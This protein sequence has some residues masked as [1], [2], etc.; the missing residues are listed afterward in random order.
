MKITLLELKSKNSSIIYKDFAGGLGPGF[1]VGKSIFSKAIE[2]AKAKGVNLPIV[3]FGYLYSILSKNGHNVE[4][5]INEIPDSDLVLI[6]SSLCDYKLEIEMAAKIKK[7]TKAKVGFI[8]PL[9]SS[10]PELFLEVADFIIKGEPEYIVS[11]LSENWLPEGIVESQDIKNLDDLP[12]PD[13]N[14]FPVNKTSYSPSLSVRPV[15][16]ILSSRGC[17]YKCNYCPYLIQ[18]KNWRFRSVENVLQE[19]EYLIESYSIKG[20][21]FRDPVFTAPPERAQKI[22]EGL[23]KKKFKLKWACET[24]LDL[25]TIPLLDILYESGLRVINVGIESKSEEILKKSS[26]KPIQYEHQE[27]IISYCDKKGINVTAF[28]ILGWPDDTLET[29]EQTV[30]YAKELN[31]NVAGFTI[32][33]PFPGTQSFE[34]FKD[35]LITEDLTKFDAH[36]LV[37]KHDCFSADELYKIKENAFLSY[38]YRPKYLIKFLQRR[39]R[40]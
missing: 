31:T 32:Y 3:A 6:H 21:V 7:E 33:T 29:I 11:K 8:G 5:K 37:Y 12:F 1:S 19:I 36:H 17:P 13:W 40:G 23:I 25:L 39:I 27:N 35:K 24:R 10:K 16:P 28:Y 15:L 18:Y 34:K 30:R 9:S 20:L 14:F 26:R 38:Y 22:A 4:C 2:M